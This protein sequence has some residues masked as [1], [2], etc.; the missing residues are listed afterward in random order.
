MAR[1]A[2]KSE[3]EDSL[4]GNGTEEGGLLSS[5]TNFDI[6]IEPNEVQTI[7]PGYATEPTKEG[8]LKL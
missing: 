6:L 3:G 4:H 8:S 1:C 5:A 7:M 2:T